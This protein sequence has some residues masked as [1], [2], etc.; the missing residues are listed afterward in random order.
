MATLN[1]SLYLIVWQERDREP[2]WLHVV[3][4]NLTETRAR[5]YIAKHLLFVDDNPDAEFEYFWFER[6]EV[7]EGVGTKNNYN[8]IVAQQ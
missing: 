5:K 6:I 2:D 1:K 4:D 8:V 7:A 3:A